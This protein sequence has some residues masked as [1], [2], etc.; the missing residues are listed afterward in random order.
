MPA[1]HDVCKTAN[2]L[3]DFTLLVNLK[4]AI[5]LILYLSC[6]AQKSF[7][8]QLEKRIL[9]NQSHL[10]LSGSRVSRKP[11]PVCNFI[12]N[13]TSKNMTKLYFLKTMPLGIQFSSERRRYIYFRN[14]GTGL[15][16]ATKLPL[17]YFMVIGVL[18]IYIQFSNFIRK[19]HKRNT[20]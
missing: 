5:T 9:H 18:H 6:S 13:Y 14:N 3:Q 4:C 17:F 2:C 16:R 8:W 20:F 15:R 10:G 7:F 19:I 1:G 11:P 12:S